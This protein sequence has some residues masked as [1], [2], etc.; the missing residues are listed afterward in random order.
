MSAILPFLGASSVSIVAF[1]EDQKLEARIRK[2][3]ADRCRRS[4]YKQ[5]AGTSKIAFDQSGY[6]HEG[7]ILVNPRVRWLGLLAIEPH[8]L[9]Y[10]HS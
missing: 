2:S 9:S 5:R 8:G 3:V 4:Y 7:H 10:D 1:H 6:S